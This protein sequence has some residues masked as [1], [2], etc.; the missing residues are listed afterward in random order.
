VTFNYYVQAALLDRLSRFD[1]L[2][3]KLQLSSG[4]HPEAAT[5]ASEK[6]PATH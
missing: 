5:P 3:A 6:S 1:A 4:V 2:L